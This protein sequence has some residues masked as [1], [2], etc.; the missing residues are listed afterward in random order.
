[1]GI[2]I[3]DR[4]EGRLV[5][6]D[7]HLT[8]SLLTLPPPPQIGR[9]VQDRLEGRLVP[10]DPRMFVDASGA[11]PC[12]LAIARNHY[13]LQE[14]LHPAADLQSIFSVVYQQVRL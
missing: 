7:P 5:P 2:C 14:L 10:P 11:T 13:L 8:C 9:C 12:S 1:M 4:L 3:Q 6:P